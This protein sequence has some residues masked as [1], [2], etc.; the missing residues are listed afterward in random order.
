MMILKWQVTTTI[1]YQQSFMNR[2]TDSALEA[3]IVTDDE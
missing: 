3:V 1:N 2:E